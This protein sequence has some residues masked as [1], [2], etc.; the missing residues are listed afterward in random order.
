MAYDLSR[1]IVRATDKF[2]AAYAQNGQHID[3]QLLHQLGC[4]YQYG[5]G[6]VTPGCAMAAPNVASACLSRLLIALVQRADPDHVFDVMSVLNGIGRAKCWGDCINSEDGAYAIA[7]GS[8]WF[9]QCFLTTS[10]LCQSTGHQ[11]VAMLNEWLKPVTPW[12]VLPTKLDAC[13]HMFGAPWCHFRLP[14]A[15]KEGSRP[16]ELDPS[17]LIRLERPQ[18]LPGLCQVRSHTELPILPEIESVP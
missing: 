14:V 15:D 7:G 8:V 17:S 11:V 2:L 18:F 16:T 9:I 4:P 5:P 10:E 6:I 13:E 1:S 3:K 12:A